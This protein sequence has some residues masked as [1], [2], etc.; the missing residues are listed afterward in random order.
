MKTNTFDVA[1]IMSFLK[2]VATN[3]NRVW[4][5]QNKE[6][7]LEAK[8]QFDDITRALIVRIA[9]FDPSVSHLDAKDCVYRFYRDTRFSLDKSPYKRHFGAFINAKGKKSLHCGYYFH[10]QPSTEVTPEEKE[11]GNPGGSMVAAG[12]WWLPSNI[13]KEVRLSIVEDV[14]T[15]RSLVEAPEFHKYFPAVGYEPVKTMPKGFPKDFPY[16]EYLRPRIYSWACGIDEKFLCRPDW[17]DRVAYLFSLSKPL[18]DFLD[19]TIDDYDV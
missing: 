4:F 1:P 14:D 3:N 15:Y 13:L 2:D 5:Q 16:P 11:A 9:Q 8:T 12:T 6:R 17:I 10:L 19:D 18:M 7:Y